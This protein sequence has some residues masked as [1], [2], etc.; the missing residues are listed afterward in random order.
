MSGLGGMG[1]RG[2]RIGTDVGLNVWLNCPPV[3]GLRAFGL[4]IGVWTV[5][6]LG[7]FGVCV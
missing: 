6:S 2:G 1:N 7:S 3:C 4:S 5:D